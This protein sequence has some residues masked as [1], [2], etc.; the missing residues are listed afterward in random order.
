M[1]QVQ[2]KSAQK[3]PENRKYYKNNKQLRAAGVPIDYTEWQLDEII[4]C[5][6][7]PVY[8]CKT[9]MKIVHVDRGL[10][11][12]VPYPYQERIIQ[13]L[14]DNRFVICKIPRQSGKTTVTVGYILHYI[15]FNK[16]VKV[17]ILANKGTLARDILDRLKK[18]FEYLPPWLQ[19]GVEIWNKGSIELENGSKV[20]ADATA[21]SSIR[22]QTFNLV[23]L[24]EFA[25]IHPN[26]ADDFM[27]SVYPTISSGKTTRVIIV[28]TPKGM[29]K[30]YKIWKDAEE[31]KNDYIPIEASWR[32]VPGRDDEWMEETIK[33]IGGQV[34]FDQEFGCDFMGSQN[35]LIDSVTL[36]NLTSMTPIATTDQGLKI[37]K[38][39]YME[40]DYTGRPINRGQYI[41][42]VDVARGLGG[43]YSVASVWRFDTFPYEQVATFRSNTISPLLF[44]DVINRLSKM[45]NDAY[46]L[47]ELNDLGEQVADILYQ[48]LECE[49]ILSTVREKKKGQVLYGGATTNSQFGLKTD[50]KTK[51][52]GCSNL[53]QLMENQKLIIHDEETIEEFCNFVEKRGSYEADQGYHDDMVMTAVLLGWVSTQDLFKDMAKRDI[54]KEI[55][56]VTSKTLDDESIPF[57]MISNGLDHHNDETMPMMQDEDG[58]TWFPVMSLP[59]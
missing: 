45:Y 8:F 44:P 31:H 57:I 1:T 22:G 56:D 35:T 47:L 25:H 9:Y 36:R 50:K 18:S 33:N 43:D 49:T 2:K 37:F 52:I 12:L 24:D 16:D 53:K 3:I 41:I 20:I 7:D 40:Y 51:R 11:N 30:F 6:T 59:Y 32:E 38:R 19:Q 13:S 29:N 42:T 34:A 48:D 27:N 4:K 15:L 46:V 17:A 28:S 54:R 39:P 21:G 26:Q 55:S 14:T 23:L 58:T 5:E 10:I